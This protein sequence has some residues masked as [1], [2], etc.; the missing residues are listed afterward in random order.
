LAAVA[1]KDGW[2]YIDVAGN[3]V[4]R[5][6]YDA[7]RG[8]REG[9]AAVSNKKGQWGYIDKKANIVISYQYHMAENFE[10]GVARVMRG[11]KVININKENKL[12]E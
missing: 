8:F 10:N 5:P 11:D 12:V 1:T 4:I 7:A 2:G 6:Q 3:F 9:L